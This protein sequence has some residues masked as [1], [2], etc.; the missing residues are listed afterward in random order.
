MSGLMSITGEPGGRPVKVGVPIADL[1]CAQFC[2]Y[3]ILAAYIARLRTGEGQE[4][5]AS[6]LESAI[7][8]SVWETSGYF[9]TGAVPRPLGSAHRTAAPYQA[10]RTSDGY[11][12]IGAQTPNTWLASSGA[13]RPALAD[14]ERSPRTRSGWRTCRR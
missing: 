4:I 7:A 14:D 8:L 6:L 3:G 12:T 5:E 11:V 10:V 1:A 9:A 13:R 2:V